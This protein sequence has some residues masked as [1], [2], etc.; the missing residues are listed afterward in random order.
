MSGGRTAVFKCN[1][2]RNPW[3]SPWRPVTAEVE[4]TSLWYCR[5]PSSSALSYFKC[6]A[7]DDRYRMPVADTFPVVA[8]TITRVGHGDPLQPLESCRIA[9]QVVFSM[10]NILAN[11]PSTFMSYR[12]KARDSESKLCSL[13]GGEASSKRRLYALAKHKQFARY[14]P[15]STDFRG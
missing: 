2:E 15:D 7:H 11:D 3:W 5:G 14:W 4:P 12:R 6:P 10:T 1:I 9:L 13:G 8:W